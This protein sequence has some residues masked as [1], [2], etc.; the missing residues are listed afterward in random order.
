[1]DDNMK[2]FLKK[3]NQITKDT[4]IYIKVYDDPWYYPTLGKIEDQNK[5]SDTWISYDND[6]REYITVAGN[7]YN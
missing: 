1:M 3:L 6:K 5:E 7:P 2:L 4:G